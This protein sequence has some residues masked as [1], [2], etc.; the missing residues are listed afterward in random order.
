MKPLDGDEGKPR[1]SLEGYTGDVYSIAWSPNGKILA[2]G[3]DDRTV[4]FWDAATGK[5]G[6][7]HWRGLLAEISDRK[8]LTLG[9]KPILAT[10]SGLLSAPGFSRLACYITIQNRPN[11]R[12]MYPTAAKALGRCCCRLGAL[13]L[14]PAMSILPRHAGSTT[15]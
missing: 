2:T 3:S 12:G 13:H 7:G 9:N 10:F 15:L 11:H 8:H 6:G 5:F 4:K 14:E 1:V